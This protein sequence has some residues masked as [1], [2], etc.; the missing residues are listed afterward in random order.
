MIWEEESEGGDWGPPFTAL[1]QDWLEGVHTDKQGNT[2]DIEDM[3]DDYLMNVI[4]MFEDL[5][6]SP[7]EEELKK[8]GYNI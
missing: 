2:H 5:D 7:L 3:S 8:R 6:T 1:E 4:N